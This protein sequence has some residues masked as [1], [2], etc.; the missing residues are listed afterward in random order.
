M[1][2]N[3]RSQD[4]ITLVELTGEIDG[5]TAPSAQARILPLATPGCKLILD[6]TQVGYM[7]SAGLRMLLSTYRQITSQKG[8]ILLVGLS[9]DIQDIMSNTGFLKFFNTAATLEAGMAAIA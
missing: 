3:T 1:E 4:G 6:M 9:E 8:H 2:I 5:N 7:S